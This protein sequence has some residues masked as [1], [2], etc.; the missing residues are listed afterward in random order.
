MC[1]CVVGVYVA[2]K[3]GWIAEPDKKYKLYGALIGAAGAAYAGPQ[4]CYRSWWATLPMMVGYNA[5]KR[6]AR[7]LCA[8][9]RAHSLDRALRG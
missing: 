3:Q 2:E 7:R 4:R 1:E 6:Y 5:V 8:T 9:L